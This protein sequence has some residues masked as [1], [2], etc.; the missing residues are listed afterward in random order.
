MKLVPLVFIVTIALTNVALTNA[1]GAVIDTLV[2][3]V[4]H[5]KLPSSAVEDQVNWGFVGP[6]K[7]EV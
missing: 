2:V 3:G 4:R 5:F 7:M 1:G 6:P